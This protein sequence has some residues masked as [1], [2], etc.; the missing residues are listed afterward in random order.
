[1]PT[2]FVAIS[3]GVI[4]F[5]LRRP[6]RRRMGL[7]AIVAVVGGCVAAFWLLPFALRLGYSND[8]GWE[9][10]SAYRKWLFPWLLKAADSPGATNTH[11]LKLV[12]ALAAAGALGG[13]A[14][15]RRPTLLITG[16]GLVAAAAFRYMRPPIV[17]WNARAL[18]FWYLFLYLAAAAGVAEAANAVGIL[19]GRRPK[20]S[21]PTLV[22]VAA[23]AAVPA[24]HLVGVGAGA[25]GGWP[26][27]AVG[28]TGEDGAGGDGT[29]VTFSP[30]DEL[31]PNRLPGLVVPLAMALIVWLFVGQTVG[32]VPPWW[33][34][35]LRLASAN[36]HNFVIDW[37][38][39]NYSGYERK[40]NYAEYR[41]VVDTMARVG[42]TNGCGRAMWEY[43]PQEDRF[44]TPMALMLLPKWTHGCIGSMEGLFFESSATVPY[45]FV[46]QSELSKVPSSAMRN[47]PYSS[48]LD[49]PTGIAHLRLLG[50]K[51]YMA[52]TPEAQAAARAIPGVHL[53]ATTSHPYPVPY[54]QKTEQ[55]LWEVY[56]IDG[57]EPV[58]PLAYQP[59]VMTGVSTTGKGWIR[60]NLCTTDEKKCPPGWYQEPSRWD[61]PLAASGPAEWAR[62]KGADPNPPRI[63]VRPAVVSN[64]RM[65]DDRI[66]FDVDA[67]GSPVLVKTS[68]FPNWQ[69]S[70]GR[71]PWRVTPNLMVVIPTSTHVSLHYGFTPVDNA[72][73]LL[74]VGGLVAAGWLSWHE[75]TGRAGGSVPVGLMGGAEGLTGDGDDLGGRD[76]RD[77]D[78]D[79]E[80]AELLADGPP[81]QPDSPR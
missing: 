62:V 30:S 12:V 42:A 2:V 8:M 22:D 51:Y 20:S 54:D 53:I 81:T 17:I 65:A 69:A 47:L 41:D 36:D 25:G 43:E 73:R 37:A 50:V 14:L 38:N 61:V 7:T 24:R 29:A 4:L 6:T 59:V 76:D 58:A 16:L 72:G 64:I 63:P 9:R 79:H 15:R 19:F 75:L 66:S 67:P 40:S 32:A 1:L 45:H 3:G 35:A 31:V 11:H 44:G 33:P 55:R 13:L 68:Y 27:S 78:L 77:R 21:E 74:T 56:E 49:V 26:P 10:T 18:P 23:P 48:G 28:G 34:N 70:G 52:I 39:W 71:G 60:V 80:L 5:L 46:N 57:A